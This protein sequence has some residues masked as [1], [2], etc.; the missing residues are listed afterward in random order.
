MKSSKPTQS[1]K[2]TRMI[3]NVCAILVGALQG[4]CAAA[5]AVKTSKCPTHLSDNKATILS[6]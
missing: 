6:P 4:L 3:L 5:L 1:L 2:E